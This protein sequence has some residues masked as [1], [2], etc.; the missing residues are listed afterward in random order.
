MEMYPVKYLL[1]CMCSDV[2]I[3]MFVQEVLL[4]LVLFQDGLNDQLYVLKHKYR[5]V[6]LTLTAILRWSFFPKGKPTILMTHLTL[7]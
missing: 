7:C 4:C 5:R 1:G 2:H 6:H 3:E